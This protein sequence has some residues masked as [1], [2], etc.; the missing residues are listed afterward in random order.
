MGFEL[1]NLP[2]ANDMRDFRKYN[3]W[4][5]SHE[6]V[7][8]IYDFTRTFPNEEIFGITSEIRRASSS[9][10]PNIA[11]GCGRGSDADFKRFLVF[12]SGSA[13]EVTYLL[14]LAKDLNYLNTE[15][16]ESLEKQI[17]IIHK[18]I[19]SLINKLK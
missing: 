18:S 9:I 6:F 13:S 11:E 19:Y 2:K 16:F 7:L 5:K 12:A 17:I 15:D 4:E 14:I 8:R 3:V 1:R 10:P